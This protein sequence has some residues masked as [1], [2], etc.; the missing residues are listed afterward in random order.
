MKGT[1]IVSLTALLLSACSQRHTAHI[2]ETVDIVAGKDIVL[3]GGDVLSVKRRDG[4]SLEGIRIV[5]SG[6]DGEETIITAEIGTVTQGPKQTVEGQPADAK[7]RER[8]KV[9]F[10]RNPAT[11]TLFNANVQIKT[12]SGTTRAIA[13][14]MEFTF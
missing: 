5:R 6:P 9:V 14:R 7:T 3:L 13:E 11:V 10:M 4:S 8:L 2:D 1:F 12:Q